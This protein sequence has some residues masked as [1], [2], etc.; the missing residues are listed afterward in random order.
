[1]RARRSCNYG[2]GEKDMP[3]RN[4]KL[5]SRMAIEIEIERDLARRRERVPKSITLHAEKA[6]IAVEEEIKPHYLTTGDPV[7]VWDAIASIGFAHSLL[8]RPIVLPDWILAYL[9]NAATQI[10]ARAVGYQSGDK[11]RPAQPTKNEAGGM[12]FYSDHFSGLTPEQ[13]TD[14]VLESLGF[15]GT[16]GENLLAKAYRARLSAERVKEVEALH[17]GGKGLKVKD[18]VR[19]VYPKGGDERIQQYYRERKKLT[20]VERHS[21]K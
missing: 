13:R 4:P 11:G 18:A 14:A 15:K 16:Q 2:W 6:L 1:M 20:P 19:E 17:N 21:K 10:M 12:T 9:I 5:P 7:C 8:N 3:P